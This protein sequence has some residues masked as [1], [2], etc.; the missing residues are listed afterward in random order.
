[1]R[2]SPSVPGRVA[3]EVAGPGCPSP[4]FPRHN[5]DAHP[6]STEH[7]AFAGRDLLDLL[8][9][10]PHGLQEVLIKLSLLHPQDGLARSELRKQECRT[11]DSGLSVH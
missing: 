9:Q 1:M 5:L 11:V 8:A 6:V 7:A 4:T 2:V 3:G 10:P